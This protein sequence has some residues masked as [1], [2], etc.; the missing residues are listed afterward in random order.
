MPDVLM[1]QPGETFM[2][3][4]EAGRIG[5]LLH[6][7]ADDVRV[8]ARDEVEIAR[9]A[10]EHNV[11]SASIDAAAIVIGAIVALI[12]LGFACTA[13]A[14]GLAHALPLWA[15]LLIFAGIYIVLGGIVAGVAAKKLKGAAKPDLR[16]PV[17]EATRT[18]RGMKESLHA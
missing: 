6:R 17:D 9:G 12:G 18:L 13:A 10:L 15:S 14:V 11:K 4:D 5:P 3:P 16:V 8:I 1:N 2:P 7:I